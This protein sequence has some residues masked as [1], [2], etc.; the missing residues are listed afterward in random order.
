M[1]ADGGSRGNPGPAAYGALVRDAQTGEVLAEVAEPIGTASNNVAEYRGLIAG[2]VA[3]RDVDPGARVEVRMD[4]KLV[5]EQMSGRW[6]I[7][8]P[9]MKPLAAQARAVLPPEQVTYRW[10]PRAQN[11]Y[12]DRLLNEALDAASGRDPAARPV[13]R[14]AAGA[15]SRALGVAPPGPV[16]VDEA[17][18]DPVPQNTLVGWAGDLGAPTSFLLLRHGETVHTVDKRFSGTGGDDPPLNDRGLEQAERVAARLAALPQGAGVDAVVSSPL[19]R[20]RQTAGIVAGVLAVEVGVDEGFRECAFGEWD[21]RTFAEVQAKW[22]GEL[23][24]WLG[25]T[26]VAPPGGESFDALGERVRLARDRTI[27]RHAGRRVLVVSHV[28]PIKQLVR[29]ALGAPGSALYR[30]ELSPASLT[31]VDWYADGNASMRVFNDTA[32]L[33]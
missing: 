24:A 5:V 23:A 16:R 11:G 33:S 30:M 29:L 25:S 2:L 32:H 9:S 14:L 18:I 1:E 13:S 31:T 22:P 19:R 12:A 3:A 21:G 6:Q 7:K 4:S 8:H 28:T 26:T 27:S 10:V 15:G 20:T 17:E